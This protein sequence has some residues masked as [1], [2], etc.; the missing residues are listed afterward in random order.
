[1][2]Q[3]VLSVN[4]N[5]SDVA[6]SRGLAHDATHMFVAYDM[7]REAHAQQTSVHMLQFGANM[8]AVAECVRSSA[9]CS[10]NTKMSL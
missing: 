7:D 2:Q 9:G 1:M 5:T 6:P 3:Q 10:A 8:S 4:V